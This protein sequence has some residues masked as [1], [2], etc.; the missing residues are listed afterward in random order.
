MS[1]L[2]DTIV[3][4]RRASANRRL[5]PPE[6]VLDAHPWAAESPTADAAEPAP[7]EAVD[8][9]APQAVGDLPAESVNGHPPAALN[10]HAVLLGPEPEPEA[11]EQP[12]STF[13]AVTPEP[14]VKPPRGPYVPAG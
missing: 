12:T 8:E 1:G 11:D 2:I 4:R 6:D 10:G 14:N 13:N 3:R 7:P 5:G 9:P